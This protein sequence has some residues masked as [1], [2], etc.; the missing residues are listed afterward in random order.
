MDNDEC[1]D[2]NGGCDQVCTNLPGGHECSCLPGYLLTGDSTCEDADECLID[3]GGCSQTQLC[4][5][6]PGSILCS[7]MPGMKT[8][9]TGCEDVN[10]CSQSNG[11]CDQLCNNKEG[12]HTCEC[13]NGYHLLQ[14]RRTCGDIN[15]CSKDN[16]GCS[17]NCE[18][19]DGGRTCS[20]PAGWTLA[21]GGYKCK[22]VE[23]S[24][25]ALKRP[26]FGYFKCTSRRRQSGYV[27]GSKCRLRC[28]KGY[29]AAAG[30]RKKCL[31]DSSWSGGQ[32][33]CLPV[34]CPALSAPLHGQ[35]SPKYCSMGTNKILTKCSFECDEG[36][37]QSGSKY[38]SCN[39][40][41]EW[42]YPEGPPHCKAN[43]PP[44]FIMCPADQTKPLPHGSSSVYVMFS[45]P[46]TN[47]DWFR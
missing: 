22:Q 21:H 31:P 43:F 2:K 16:G 30:V 42:K 44:P 5:N 10:E 3:N 28:R 29:K 17:H 12:S 45:Q 23:R 26:K 41:E 8:T 35:V 47:V 11:G 40:K 15:E 14:D 4:V 25:P 9:D 37:L 6:T 20:C 33:E 19:T 39:D 7:C 18:N 34:A 32:G 1:G 36:F 46:K 24:C 27:M 13:N 38:A